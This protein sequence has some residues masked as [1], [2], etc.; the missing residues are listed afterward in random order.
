MGS[1]PENTSY[2]QTMFVKYDSNACFQ[3]E[4]NQNKQTYLREFLFRK[5]RK[6]KEYLTKS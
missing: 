4:K 6:Q 1:E 2:M 3:N 5:N